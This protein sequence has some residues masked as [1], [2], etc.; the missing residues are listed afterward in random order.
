MTLSPHQLEVFEALEIANDDFGEQ[1]TLH[2]ESDETVNV[3]VRLDDAVRDNDGDEPAVYTGQLRFPV[4]E[5][6]KLQLDSNPVLT[7]T[8]RGETWH[9]V[10]VGPESY[11][12]IPIGI[13]R[14][15]QANKHTNIF[16]LNE[17]QAT[18]K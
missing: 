4:S 8:I 13:R 18:W 16:D 1:I 2:G 10:D 6:A 3:M 9:I 12:F 17:Q 11:G 7:A 14:D 15:A 5:T